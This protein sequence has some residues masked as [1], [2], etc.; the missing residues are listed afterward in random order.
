MGWPHTYYLSITGIASTA[1]VVSKVTA[2]VAI[3]ERELDSC[4][5]KPDAPTM[6][7]SIPRA[8]CCGSFSSK[9]TAGKDESGLTFCGVLV[10]VV[11]FFT[12][13]FGGV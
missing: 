2:A 3:I 8:I 13:R 6:R 10:L 7:M 9:C 4:P 5:V 12:Y 11:A 1:V